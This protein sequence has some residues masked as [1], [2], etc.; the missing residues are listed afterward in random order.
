MLKLIK[1][2]IKKIFSKKSFYIVTIIFVLYTFLISA[3]YANN[4][5]G[6]YAPDTYV[7]DLIEENK[8]L[9]L[10]NKEN[11]FIY[12][13]NSARIESNDLKKKYSSSTQIYLIENYVYNYLHEYYQAYYI[14]K[15]ELAKKEK[16]MKDVLN[17]IEEEDW[18][19]FVNLDIENLKKG[20]ISNEIEKERYEYFI[21]LKEY[22]LNNNIN[23]DTNNYLNKAIDSI[24][25]NLYEYLNLKNKDKLTSTEKSALENIEES[26]ITNKYILENKVD[27]NNP[28]TLRQILSNFSNEF[29][30]F[31]LIY[32]ILISSSIISEEFNKGT[33]KYLL[34][35]P[36][37]RS[38]ILTS[39]LLTIL[40]LVPFILILMLLIELIVGGFILGFNSLS[41]P[42]L[43]FSSGSIKAIPLFNYVTGML[44]AS[45]P[46]YLVILIFSFMLSA[47]TL[48]TS[49]ACTLSFIFYLVGNVISNLASIYSFK[50]FKLLIPL[51]WDFTYL[52]KG[53]KHPFNVSTSV[54][55]SITIL[56]IVAMLCIT[57]VYFRK[58]DVKNI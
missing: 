57:Y 42:V 35:K 43:A 44:L 40:L 53:I 30:L 37:K 55:V 7:E 18:K 48:S 50:V 47:I 11:L 8:N 29:G 13:N 22:R 39:K 20:K 34:T 6:S 33:I 51:Y 28:H 1:N 14:N 32:V 26:I 46:M 25:T 31:I 16:E 4:I 49:A 12:A 3:I 17:K 41:V 21:M 58:K 38:T 52:V 45:L 10:S 36:Y 5:E 24:E 54:S 23:F 27:A 9:D 56:Y 15:S 19:Y 2:E